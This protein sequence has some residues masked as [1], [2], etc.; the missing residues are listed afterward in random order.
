[1]TL[2]W[3]FVTFWLPWLLVISSCI[4]IVSDGRIRSTLRSWRLAVPST[5][6]ADMSHV[7]AMPAVEPQGR[8]TVWIAGM[9]LTLAVGILGGYGIRDHQLSANTREYFGVSVL[10]QQSDH[11]YTVKIPG[12]SK[13]YDWEFCHPLKMPGPLID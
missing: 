1:M 6:T 13:D 3:Q 9:M 4:W 12:Y 8:R 5:D 10:S 11:R 7:E 2:L